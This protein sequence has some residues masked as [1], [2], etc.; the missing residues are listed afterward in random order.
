M[1]LRLNNEGMIKPIHAMLMRLFPGL[2]SKELYTT[3]EQYICFIIFLIFLISNVNSILNIIQKLFK[4]VLRN[5][6]YTFSV[7]TIMIISSFVF[8]VSLLAYCNLFSCQCY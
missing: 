4:R 3:W 1:G 2:I 8:F 6:A 5:Y 7:P